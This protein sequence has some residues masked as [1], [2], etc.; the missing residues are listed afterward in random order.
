V[1]ESVKIM[2]E[3]GVDVNAVNGDGRTALD[4]A[5]LLEYESVAEFLASVGAMPGAAPA[6]GG[7]RRR[8]G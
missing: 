4:G 1:L 8:P 6:G 5:R 7:N 3:L 2:V